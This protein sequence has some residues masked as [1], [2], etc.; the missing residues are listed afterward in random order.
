M[1]T[2]LQVH[3]VCELT[4]NEEYFLQPSTVSFC[5]HKKT[6]KKKNVLLA[7]SADFYQAAEASSMIDSLIL[8]FQLDCCDAAKNGTYSSMW[9]V[10]GLSLVINSQYTPSIQKLILAIDHSVTNL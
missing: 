2:E 7:T 4:L 3:T 9:H 8:C 5:T 10:H 6:N 1:H